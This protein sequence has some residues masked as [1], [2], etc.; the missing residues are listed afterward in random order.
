MK[1][2]N[3]ALLYLLGDLLEK[4]AINLVPRR[5]CN[6][7]VILDFENLIQPSISSW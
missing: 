7:Y 6:K 4:I 5:T 1:I 3:A 2:E